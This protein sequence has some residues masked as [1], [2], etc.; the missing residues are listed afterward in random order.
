MNEIFDFAVIGAGASGLF[1]L[2]GLK[3]KKVLI[4]EGNKKV[5]LKLLATGGGKC[6]FTNLN[7][8]HENY[9]SS[10]PH[11]VK[12]FIAKF[13]TYDFLNLIEKYNIP[14]EERDNGKLF[15]LSSAKDILE[16][17]LKEGESKNHILKTECLVENVQ[18]INADNDTQSIFQIITNQK[19][20]FAKKVLIASG[21]L[22][23]PQ[24]GATNIACKIAKNF[25]IKT[26][27]M[28]PALA[29]IRYPENCN[30]D[31]SSLSG[32][33]ITT[34]ATIGKRVFTDQL[35][36]THRGFSGPLALNLS[37]FIDGETEIIFNYLPEINVT[38]LLQEERNNKKSLHN[39]LSEHLPKSFVKLL[40]EK[41]N[42]KEYS[43]NLSEIKKSEIEKIGMIFNQLTLKVSKVDGFDKAEVTRGGICVDEIYPKTMEAK[44]VSGLYFIGEALDVT[45]MLGGYNLHWAWASAKMFIDGLE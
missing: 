9:I 20:F 6:N 8:S 34:K 35:L 5:A 38:N 26:V 29:G 18:K 3:D 27:S 41:S 10:N 31:F 28:H 14:Y 4:L 21:G 23:Y 12:S 44:K 15:T 42:I 45:G 43:K 25:G 36:F 2:E 37:L 16:L 11:F 33:A 13:G 39:I 19:D 24:M 17:L 40:L 30:F 7:L 1:A 32:I 22:S